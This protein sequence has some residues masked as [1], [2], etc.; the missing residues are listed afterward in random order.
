[1]SRWISALWP[2]LTSLFLH[3]LL[4]LT[5]MQ[6]TLSSNT[7]ILP[8]ILFVNIIE[9]KKTVEAKSEPI[10]ALKKKEEIIPVK[11]K[12][13]KEFPPPT[14]PEEKII[15]PLVMTHEETK[16]E[17]TLKE[18]EGSGKQKNL[19][20]S[21]QLETE[22]KNLRKAEKPEESGAPVPGTMASA[23]PLESSAEIG[24]LPASKGATWLGEMSGETKEGSGGGNP[25]EG[26]KPEKGP[27]RVGKSDGSGS[28]GEGKGRADLGSY[29]AT[30]RRRIE[31]AMRYPREARRKGYEGKMIVSFQIDRRG[32]VGEIRLVQSCGYPDL[33]EEGMATLR[34]ASPFP[35][36]LLIE[37]EKLV[38]EVPIL[39]KLE[40][41]K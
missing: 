30:A 33:D 18:E 27:A 26:E 2:L 9:E 15:P 22:D 24:K 32:E 4:G 39:F 16:P 40:Q 31:K 36:P 3:V 23:F 7:L 6:L 13:R 19:E 25:G 1:M 38:L 12:E 21:N 17:E 8:N 37:K 10:P 11:K 35:S 28:Q 20:K 34:R 5:V 29:L 41:R 14:N